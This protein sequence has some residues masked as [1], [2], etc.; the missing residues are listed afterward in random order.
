M[1]SRMTTVMMSVA[2]LAS[3]VTLAEAGDAPTVTSKPVFS[4]TTTVTGQPIT[5]PEHPTVM[6]VAATFEP[7]ARLPVHKHPYPHYVYVLEGTL[8]IVNE[9]TGKSFEVHPGEF[10]V[11]MQDTWHY[12]KNNGRTPV[13]LLVID[14][15]P[16]GVTSNVVKRKT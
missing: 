6:A 10:F 14:Q 13:K 12:G 1:N 2:A 15:V 7:G 5:V 11:E 16:P 4:S 3:L 8:T 9:E